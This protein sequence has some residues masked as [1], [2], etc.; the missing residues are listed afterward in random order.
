MIRAVHGSGYGL[1]LTV[2][3][4]V[5]LFA[6][7]GEEASGQQG[8][9]AAPG[10]AAGAGLRFE[11]DGFLAEI[12]A[13]G[14]SVLSVRLSAPTTGWV[15][16]GF[17]P[18]AMMKDADLVIGYVTP[19]GELFLRDDFGTSVTG[20]SPDTGLG[21]TSDFFGADGSEREGITSISFL[22]PMDSGD[23]YDRPLS[24][25]ATHTVLL[26]YGRE[27]ADDFTSHHSW[28]TMVEADF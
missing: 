27:G 16:V 3:L 26:A 23:P 8:Q 13:V 11:E 1:A 18:T 20:H 19:E 24:A 2:S 15:A 22:I 5:A 7:S 17:D 6:C 12:E 28:A 21:G 10:P 4:L 14:D 25:G 9:D